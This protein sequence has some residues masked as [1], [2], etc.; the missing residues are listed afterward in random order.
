VPD[1]HLQPSRRQVEPCTRQVGM[2]LELRRKAL[3][4]YRTV[5]IYIVLF[6]LSSCNPRQRAMRTAMIY[7]NCLRCFTIAGLML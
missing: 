2:L 5:T 3:N 7:K 4:D 1:S 6:R